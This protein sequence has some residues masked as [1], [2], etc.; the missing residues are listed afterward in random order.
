MTKVMIASK[1]VYVSTVLKF[2][3]N[4]CC[5]QREPANVQEPLLKSNIIIIFQVTF[6]LRGSS[7]PTQDLSNLMFYRIEICFANF[8]FIYA[9][10]WHQAFSLTIAKV[11]TEAAY[12][13]QKQTKLDR[14]IL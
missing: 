12:S 1:N 3:H 11:N 10:I 9:R 14:F 13:F 5:F 4:I 2:K 7:L 8:L 6:S